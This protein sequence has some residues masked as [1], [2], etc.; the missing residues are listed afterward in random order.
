MHL[1]ALVGLVDDRGWLLMQERDEHA[2]LD[3]DTWG[4][5]GGGVE[6][7]ESV[8]E[9]AGRELAEETGLRQELEP[10]GTYVM[11]CSIEGEEDH[12]GVFTART[13]ATDA[14]IVCTEGRQIVFVAPDQIA[15]LDLTPSARVI[16]PAVL[17]A[18]A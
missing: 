8:R 12:F 16:V 11:P 4:L 13:S 14:D 6:P 3:P 7:G 18:H 2:Q 10:L 5:V 9:A 15:Q 17:A 1:V